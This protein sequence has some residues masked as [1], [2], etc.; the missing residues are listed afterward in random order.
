MMDSTKITSQLKDND[1]SKYYALF[2]NATATI[3][4]NF[5]ARIIKNAGDC[6]ILYFPKTSDGASNNN[7]SSLKD[8]LEC[9]IT[10]MAAHRAINAKLHEEKLPPLNYRISADFGR[11]EVARSKSSQSD[12]L[13]GSAMNMCAK[14]NS[15][16]PANGMVIG[17]EMYKLVG[18]FKEY[19]FEKIQNPPG[20]KYGY[21]A[22]IVQSK[23]KRIILNPFKRV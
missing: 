4:K 17:E 1:L 14:I 15:K 21:N 3:G 13:F 6:L 9:G 16:A 5:G 12:D 20:D 8:V 23:Q 18:S 7:A 10:M 2:L 11:V 22:Y 19:D